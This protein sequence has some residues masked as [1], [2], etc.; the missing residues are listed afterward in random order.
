MSA[1][2]VDDFLDYS[3]ELVKVFFLIKSLAEVVFK[4][5]L[6]K[7]CTDQPS[8]TKDLLSNFLLNVTAMIPTFQGE[9]SNFHASD[10]IYVRKVSFK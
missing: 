5:A 4:T 6:G 8:V 9:D 7:G 1:A 2:V 10:G 3:G